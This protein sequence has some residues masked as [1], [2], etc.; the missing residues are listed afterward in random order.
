MVS[1]C[2]SVGRQDLLNLI[3]GNT[4]EMF[5]KGDKGLSHALILSLKRK[6]N[7]LGIGI[8]NIYNDGCFINY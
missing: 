7:V 4:R 6:P 2:F 8:V 1:I 5:R 3:I